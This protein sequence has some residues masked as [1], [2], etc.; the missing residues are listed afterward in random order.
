MCLIYIEVEMAYFLEDVEI[1]SRSAVFANK[2][3][4]LSGK[5][6]KKYEIFS[7]Q[8]EDVVM[9]IALNVAEGTARHNLGEWIDFFIEA[10]VACLNSLSLLMLLKDTGL[11]GSLTCA[12]LKAEAGNIESLL[13]RII[14]KGV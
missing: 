10:R 4:F 14:E 7:R 3:L 9:S 2:M 5:L 6:G 13:A 1:Y 12:A 11:I 8:I